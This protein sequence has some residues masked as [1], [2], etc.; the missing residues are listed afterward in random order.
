[1]DNFG[2]LDRLVLF[3][4]CYESMKKNY[5]VRTLTDDPPPFPPYESVRF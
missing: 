2:C 4:V 1:M 3:Q 5:S